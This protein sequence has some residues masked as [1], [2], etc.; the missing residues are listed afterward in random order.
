M[1]ERTAPGAGYDTVA[2]TLHWL[3]FALLIVQFAVAWTMPEIHRNTQP[4]TLINLHL[5][6]GLTILAVIVLRLLWRLGHRAP[7]LADL[8]GWQRV[9]A[10]LSHALLYLL[11]IALPIMGWTAASMRDWRIEFFGLF[12]VPHIAAPNPRLAGWLGDQHTLVAYILLAVIGL[13]V[14]AALYHYLVRRD[15]VLQRMLPSAR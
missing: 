15:G 10:Q 8:P 4:E 7:P 9:V 6:F 13:H 12:P 11:L 3:I 1:V 5:S 2:K 14:L